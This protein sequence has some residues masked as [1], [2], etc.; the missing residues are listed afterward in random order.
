MF[1][2]TRCKLKIVISILIFT[3]YIINQISIFIEHLTRLVVWILVIKSNLTE[4]SE[5]PRGETPA[6]NVMAIR[7]QRHANV[8]KQ[9]TWWTSTLLRHKARPRSH[10]SRIEL[11]QECSFHLRRLQYYMDQTQE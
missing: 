10:D 1:C 8:S 11:E 6:L 5:Q 3:F 7:D 9:G 2:I 4:V